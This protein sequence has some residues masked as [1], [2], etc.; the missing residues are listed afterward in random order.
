MDLIGRSVELGHAMEDVQP[1]LLG[2]FGFEG[3]LI[4]IDG[5]G[6]AGL[7]PE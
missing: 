4:E 3:L 5:L 2:G 7:W 1:L 6:P